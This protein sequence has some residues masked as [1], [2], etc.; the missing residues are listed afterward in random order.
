MRA[1]TV[2][3]LGLRDFVISELKKSKGDMTSLFKN[4]KKIM[5]KFGRADVPI[6][7]WKRYVKG[8]RD[9]CTDLEITEHVRNMEIEDVGVDPQ[10]VRMSTQLKTIRRENTALTKLVSSAIS[11]EESN[12]RTIEQVK[13]LT[14]TI[15]VPPPTLRIG[16][17]KTKSMPGRET[18]LL[19]SDIHYG[20]VILP[21]A[22]HGINSY[23]CAEARRRLENLF[24][25]VVGISQLVGSETLHIFSLGDIFSGVIHVELMR[26]AEKS[27]LKQITELSLFFASALKGLIESKV[28]RKITMHCVVGNHGRFDQKPVQKNAHEENYESIFYEMLFQ[29]FFNSSDINIDIAPSTAMIVPVGNLRFRLEHGDDYKG[30]G[31]KVGVPVANIAENLCKLELGTQDVPGLS[32]DVAVMGHFHTPAYFCTS[33]KKQVWVNGSVVGPNEY[34]LRRCH[35]ATPPSQTVLIAEGKEVMLSAVV[36][37]APEVTN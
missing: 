2:E 29:H 34:A 35:A 17:T 22:V 37:L 21:S 32:Y 10:I 30:G 25:K 33:S 7:I 9:R 6:D 4:H 5:E 1:A 27:M 12:Q 23:C 14:K 24:E 11:I 8:T 3:A 16:T 26:T 18:I 13:E 36:S 20:E 28:Y 19:L 31:G 15:S